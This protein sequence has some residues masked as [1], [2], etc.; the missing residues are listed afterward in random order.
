[1]KEALLFDQGML[2]ENDLFSPFALTDVLTAFSGEQEQP[3]I[4][5]WQLPQT[6]IL[7][8][9]DSRV[10]Y[11]D[12]ALKTVQKENYHLLLRNAGGLGVIS[13][14]GILNVSLILPKNTISALSIDDGYQAMVDWLEQ[15]RFGQLKLTVGEI[16]DSYCPGKYDLSINGK[17]IAGIAQRRVKDGVAIMMY[18]SVNGEQNLRGNIVRSYYQSGLEEQFGIDYP[19]V[20]PASM[21]TLHDAAAFDV[22]IDSV[23]NELLQT[24]PHQDQTSFL[25]NFQQLDDYQRRIQNMYQR[26]S[27]IQEALNDL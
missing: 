1:M 20:N 4:H 14:A 11:F 9:K 10:T 19:P 24:L 15:T 5:F 8:M 6:L 3:I 12:Q 16:T 22:T 13:D 2:P 7:G 21:T 17:K 23:K 26:N 27:I 25:P 18:L